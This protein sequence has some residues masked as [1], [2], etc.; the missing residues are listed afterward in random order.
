MIQPIYK[1][2]GASTHTL[3]H[4]FGAR[5]NTKASHTGT[6]DPLAD[7]VVVALS[8]KDRF[9]KHI[10][11]DWTK[12]YTFSVLLGVATDSHDALGLITDISQAADV[13]QALSAI[14]QN[15]GSLTGTY[16][17]I[18]PRFSAGRYKGK[19]F[20][21]HA[22][23]HADL[24]IKKNTIS[25]HEMS[26]LKR[27]NISATKLLN[28]IEKSVKKVN[29]EFR[30]DSVLQGWQTYCTQHKYQHTIVTL[31][32]RTS[33]RCYI[34]GLVRDLSHLIRMP[35]T[36]LTISRTKNGPYTIDDCICLIY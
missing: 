6:L 23:E 26:V 30:Q 15:L 12:E 16:E 20:F 34:R 24:P 17:Q 13:D 31:R 10:Y 14:K 11:A 32:A 22:K 25:V 4:L 3:A 27:E 36:T 5:R 21:T 1:P 28:Q 7:G 9:D 2:V 18:Q 33:K 19:S 8:G 35:L 29:G